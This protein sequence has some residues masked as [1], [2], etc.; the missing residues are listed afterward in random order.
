MKTKARALAGVV[1]VLIVIGGMT[2]PAS[3]QKIVHQT[4]AGHGVKWL[5]WL[6][7]MAAIFTKKTGIEVEVIQ[8]DSGTYGDSL[9]VA[10]AGGM[11]PDVGD[12]LVVQAGPFVEQ[13]LVEDLRPYFDRDKLDPSNWPAIA[14]QGN[15]TPDGRLWC[16]PA[17]MT[18]TVTYY[19]GDMFSEAGLANP[20]ELGDAW[21]WDT[22]LTSARRLTIDRTGEGRPAQ[23]GVASLS[24]SIWRTM[25][26]QAG[27]KFFDRS[28][29]PTKSLF[30][31]PPVLQA[32]LFRRTFS[33]EGLI[34]G[35]W[36]FEGRSAIGF[37]GSGHIHRY[38]NV[39]FEWNVAI[40]PAGPKNR[41]TSVNANGFQI[42][43]NSQSKEEAWQW[44]R[45]LTAEPDSQISLVK[46]TGRVPAYLPVMR[47]YGRLP[48]DMKPAENWMA[49]IEMGTSPDV[50][51]PDMI[52]DPEISK[53]I[54]RMIKQVW[55]GTAAPESVLESLD[56]VINGMLK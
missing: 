5:D 29:F 15:T 23:Y 25:A 54:T 30:N 27:G 38:Q 6:E 17:E 37:S 7:E 28:I 44:I 4:T 11:P 12:L 43:A 48:V 3:A 36:P 56:Q 34:G 53:I 52:S 33:Q 14:I 18:I 55:D 46:H 21:N 49:F 45:F 42:L 8:T 50:H 24:D 9:L 32:T 47:R 16:M 20:K 39:V 10:I 1:I 40:M 22:L 26:Y 31:T 19:N 2:G 35:G 41:A 13:R 51:G